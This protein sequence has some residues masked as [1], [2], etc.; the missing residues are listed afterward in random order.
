MSEN[1]KKSKV[2]TTLLII[3]AV[4]LAVIIGAGI[5]AYLYINRSFES[6]ETKTVIIPKNSSEEA[7]ADSLKVT[8]G[9]FGETVY[10]L[11]SLRGGKAD[12]SE[13]IYRINPGEKAWDVSGQIIIGR[14]ST[15]K[16]TFNNVRLMSDFAKKVSKYFLW[17]DEK[18]AATCDSILTAKGY[19]AEEFPALF[20]PDTYQFFANATPEE[21]VNKLL[22]YH[23]RFWNKERTKKA[24]DLGLTPV[25]VATVASIVEE[26]SNSKAERPTIAR[27][28]LNRIHKGI[29][30]EA[31]PT[32]KYALGDFGLRRITLKQTKT[33]SPYNTYYTEGLPPGPI[34]IPEGATLDAVLDA[35]EN[36]FIFMCAKPDNSGTHNFSTTYAE[37]EKNARAYHEWLNSSGIK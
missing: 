36:D 16:V 12:K 37:H 30:L 19:K 17:N 21:V 15:I 28:Y 8:L 20:L 34:R 22:D 18:F 23:S 11:W 6:A 5:Y 1:K 9:D 3:G 31:D 7:L 27:L 35:P 4:I 13:G 10:N 25:E 29:K 33:P 24:S 32:V 14:S 26:E 2:K